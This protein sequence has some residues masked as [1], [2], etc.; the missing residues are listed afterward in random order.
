MPTL[1][2]FVLAV[3]V[4]GGCVPGG[5]V[6]QHADFISLW[7]GSLCVGGG[8]VTEHA[9][10]VSLCAGIVFWRWVCSWWVC[11]SACRLHQLLGWQSVLV[12]GVCQHLDF[13]SLRAGSLCVSGVC[14]SQQC[15]LRYP[16]GWQSMC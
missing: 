2:A 6:S 13:V 4:G 8:Y 16:S 5:C 1:S 10:F 7:A 14:V 12:V 3:C 11:K 9:D 15:G